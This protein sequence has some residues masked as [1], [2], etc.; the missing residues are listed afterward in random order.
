MTWLT[1]VIVAALPCALLAPLARHFAISNLLFYLV[2]GVGIGLILVP[3]FLGITNFISWYTDPPDR[4]NLTML[5]GLKH[6]G[7]GFAIAGALAGAMFWKRAGQ[8]YH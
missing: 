6:L 1:G 4:T 5:Q 7:A 2:A 8:H 3:V